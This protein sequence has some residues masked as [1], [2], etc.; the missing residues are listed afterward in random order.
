MRRLTLT[1][2]LQG[3]R[4]SP[5]VQALSSLLSGQ[6]VNA[7]AG[8]L[9]GKAIALYVPAAVFGDY[10]LEFATMTLSHSLLI[11]PVLQSLKTAQAQYGWATVFPVYRRVLLALYG[12]GAIGAGL[13][14]SLTGNVP[15]AALMLLALMGQGFYAARS[16]YLNLQG[17]FSTYSLVQATYGL[18][19]LLLF[20]LVV[21]GMGIQTVVGLWLVLALLNGLFAA[22][23]WRLAVPTRSL[24]KHAPPTDTAPGAPALIRALRTYATPLIGLAVWSWLCNYADRYLIGYYLTRAD[25]GIYSAGYGLGAKMTLLV[26]PFMLHLSSRLYRLRSE[27]GD[28]ND[29][30]TL[31]RQY[32]GRYAA[33]GLVACLVFFLGRNL[34]GQWLLSEAY[35]P[36]FLIAP[37]VA[38]GYLFLTLIHLHEIKWYVYG[39]TTFILGHYA[40][41]A[42]VNIGL[43]SLL[44]PL[45]GL[46]GAALST[47]FSYLLQLLLVMYLYHRSR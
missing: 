33:V 18:A 43:N 5:A 16:E 29:A 36:A 35:Q 27:G 14:A 41:G 15:E 28:G 4:A 47:V 30:W 11:A 44:I 42:F 6:L 17:Q 31:Q 12:L 40:V 13:Y 9:L 3:Q 10:S 21:V 24:Q 2:W 32:I 1:P 19:N 20:L 23:V 37:M 46:P 8:L 7:G 26:G 25:V 38:L 39:Q 22:L 34:I 45:W